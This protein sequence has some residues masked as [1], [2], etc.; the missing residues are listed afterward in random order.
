MCE[1]RH[2][3]ESM[4]NKIAINL[5]LP[6]EDVESDVF[7]IFSSFCQFFSYQ[8]KP[9]TPCFEIGEITIISSEIHV[10]PFN[11]KMNG[12]KKM[13]KKMYS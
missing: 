1:R 5:Y 3:L 4:I 10:D 13:Q 9:S 2:Q 11:Y 7:S 12:H 8:N 6:S